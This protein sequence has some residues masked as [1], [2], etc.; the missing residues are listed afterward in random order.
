MKG[1]RLSRHDLIR[2]FG[3]TQRLAARIGALLAKD[4]AVT[5]TL[6]EIGGP[7][8]AV[9]KFLLHPD[10]LA[11]AQRLDSDLIAK[12]AA[13]TGADTEG[14][15][16]VVESDGGRVLALEEEVLAEEGWE[17]GS[18]EETT[19]V[20]KVESPGETRQLL[21]RGEAR[22]LFSGEEIA[23]IKLDALTGRDPETR[24]SALRK[25]LY[26]PLT[27][28]EKGSVYLKA[29][30]DPAGQV[31]TEAIRSLESMGFNRDTADAIQM[32]FEGDANTR[33]TALR[34]I[35]D[36]LGKLQP[37]ERE[38]VLVVLL[39][40]FRESRLKDAQDP[41][42][43]VLNEAS[44]VLAAHPDVVK[45]LTRTCVQQL[46]VAPL[47]L[48]PALHEL[49][50]KLCQAAAGEVLDKLWEEVDTIRD[51][52]PHAF[53]LELLI[54][55][56]KDDARLVH[57]SE[58]VV[59]E[60]LEEAHDELTRQKL[61]YGLLA[62]GLPAADA[63]VRR[64]ASATNVERTQLVPFLDVVCMDET[65]PSDVKRHAAR[66]LLDAL[67]VADRGLLMAILHARVLHQAALESDLKDALARELIPMLRARENPDLVER[68]AGMLEGL[69]EVVAPR[70]FDMIKSRPAA[71]EADIAVRVLGRIVNGLDADAA[72]VTRRVPAVFAFVSRRVSH[73]G[74]KLAGYAEALGKMAASRV[75]TPEQAR[76]AFEML[77]VQRA[78][79]SYKADAVEALAQIAAS[80]AAT[81]DQRVRAVHL[82][83]SLVERPA[84]EEETK[85]RE[86]ET[87]QGTVYELTGDVEFDS[88]TL[89]AAVGGLEAIATAEQTSDALRHQIAEQLL[90]VWQGV[91]AW[92]VIWG[93]G[94]SRRLALALGRIGADPRTEETLRASIVRALIPALER[95]S[96]VCALGEVFSVSSTSKDFNRLVVDCALRTLEQWIEPE[97][98]PEELEAVLTAAAAAA[99]RPKISSRGK[100]AR[101]LR[102]RT[103]EL[104]FDAMK[105]GHPW[106]RAPLEKM[107]DCGAVSKRL[108]DEI[109][110]RLKRASAIAILKEPRHFN[111]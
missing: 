72:F 76:E 99:V 31:R 34:R 103:A 62:I 7:G 43:R 2:Q 110:D 94:S 81:S 20:A 52:A 98:T 61:G 59:G 46:L 42:L 78:L 18:E 17:P 36:L 41:L 3:V 58:I 85:L 89:P 13:D 80:P 82:L 57:L 50:L 107:R 95:L 106:P 8:S 47:K 14:A 33:P 101:R 54:E 23:R 37:A 105:A 35:G 49:L 93:P 104:L 39:E 28:K 38:I 5:P 87:D 24:I 100:H 44:P 109:A 79:A 55:A 12:I 68:A 74:N 48:A 22:R 4:L 69:G 111:S 65:L 6:L 53:L 10:L 73:P 51:P 70:L 102:Q 19:S 40:V 27:A 60:L 96:V 1:V 45:E 108:R 21:D 71:A 66:Y 67:K 84:D 16:V 56:E 90:R 29:L 86:I 30:L 83:G 91:A 92:K 97:I 64:F 9:E 26:A 88:A 11:N 15:L 25:L 32:V 75:V 63:V 77:S